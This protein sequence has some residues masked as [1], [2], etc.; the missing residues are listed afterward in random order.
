MISTNPSEE[1]HPSERRSERFSQLAEPLRREINLHCYRML[2]SLHDAEDLVQETYLRAWRN[3]S[4]FEGGSMRAWLYRIA[5]N[6]CLNALES[7]KHA[8]RFLP[9]QIGPASAP[10]LGRGPAAEVPWLEPY[11]DSN[12]EWVPDGAPSPEARYPFANPCSSLLSLPFRNCPRVS[13]P[14]SCYVMFWAGVRPRQQP[15]WTVRSLRSTALS[16]GRERHFR[17]TI[18]SAGHRLP[19]YK[20]PHSKNSSAGIFALGKTGIWTDS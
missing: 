3:F 4:S 11:P 14:R 17:R 7:R 16:R 1:P 10:M 8:R 15:C 19:V 13:A 20:R 5:T 6:A 9:D 18:R 12:L 2:G